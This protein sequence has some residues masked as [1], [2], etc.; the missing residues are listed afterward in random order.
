MDGVLVLTEKPH[1]E[2]WLVPAKTRGV[3]LAYEKFL[4]CFGRINPDCI[5]ILFGEMP[6][7]ESEKIADEKEAAFRDI[8][9]HSVPLAP[10]VPELLRELRG[11]GIATAVGSSGPP[12]NVKLVVENG[13][14]SALFDALVDGSMV[15]QGKPAPDCFLL[16]ASKMGVPPGR[17]IV[18]ED[19]PAGI[20]AARAAGMVAVAL[21]T[22]NTREA[23]VE[24][25]AHHLFD[26]IKTLQIGI[27]RG[28]FA[29]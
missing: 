16:A 27:L 24:A 18:V 26:S 6:V 9:R 2:S 13:G 7:A 15:K 19:A 1:W 11:A 29:A 5:R 23:L 12:E 4:S 22:T 20:R 3:T 28:L 14:L 17:C 8:I 25:G 10:G 21:T